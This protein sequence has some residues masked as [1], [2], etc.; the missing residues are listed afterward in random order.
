M[1]P[2]GW[3]D[4]WWDSLVASK[5]IG[6]YKGDYSFSSLY[7]FCKEND[8]HL[9]PKY[10]YNWGDLDRNEILDIRN[11]LV[12]NGSKVIKNRFSN[13]YKEVFVKLGLFFRIEDNVIVLDEGYEPLITLLGI[14]EIG[15]KLLASELDNYSDDPLTLLSDLSEVLIKCKTPTRI[16]ASMGRPEKANE[17]RLKPPPHVLFPLGDSGGNQRL[18]NTALKERPYR[19][20]FTQGKLGSIEMVTQLRY[21]K[22]CNKETISLRC[23]K[24]S[25]MVKEDAKKR[26]VDVSEIV[27]KAMNNT[28]VG[29]LPKVKGIKELKSGPKIPES[30]KRGY[31][32]QNRFK[33]LQGWNT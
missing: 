33:S 15:G 6:K 25:T 20:G 1:Q 13:I 19:R 7:N 28:K 29:I 17:R 4:E 31:F 24:S 21:C 9:H 3:C 12:R 16:G 5:G 23:C 27:T 18:I 2:S 32:V 8:L 11:Q 26:I 30:L 14:K 10:T 22:N